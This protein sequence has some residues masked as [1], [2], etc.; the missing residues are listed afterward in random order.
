VLI[1]PYKGYEVISIS[2]DLTA[3]LWAV[4]SCTKVFSNVFASYRANGE[5]NETVS[6]I[7]KLTLRAGLK[8]EI[9][10]QLEL[11]SIQLVNNKIEFTACGFFNINF[12]F[13]RSLV[14]TVTT[15]IIVLIQVTWFK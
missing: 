3:A 15:Y 9:K 6:Q 11:F 7:Q 10:D 1:T 14:Y 4:A 12:K 2:R 13:V 8:P 5:F